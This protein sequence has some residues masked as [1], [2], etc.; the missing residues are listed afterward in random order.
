MLSNGLLT[1]IIFVGNKYF[2][3]HLTHSAANGLEF[4]EKSNESIEGT[5]VSYKINSIR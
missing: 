1:K 5:N 2:P 4:K 3:S